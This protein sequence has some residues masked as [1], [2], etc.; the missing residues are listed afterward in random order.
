ML[1]R[2]VFLCVSLFLPFV[3]LGIERVLP[4]LSMKEKKKLP[5]FYF[6]LFFSK[7]CY[8]CNVSVWPLCFIWVLHNKKGVPGFMIHSLNWLNCKYQQPA[9][10]DKLALV[11]QWFASSYN[12]HHHQVAVAHCIEG[13]LRSLFLLPLRPFIGP[14]LSK[15]F[16]CACLPVL[17]SQCPCKCIFSPTSNSL[18]D[19]QESEVVPWKTSYES[20]CLHFSPAELEDNSGWWNTLLQSLTMG[21]LLLYT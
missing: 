15:P 3:N 20:S 10:P 9:S 7:A 16:V 2:S 17:L 4:L 19:Q 6:P 13:D 12:W 14:S 1:V 8:I 11:L 18:Q 5:H 21:S